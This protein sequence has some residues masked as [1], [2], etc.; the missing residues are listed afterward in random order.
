MSWD[1]LLYEDLVKTHDDFSELNVR[2]PFW[3]DP[4]PAA[5]H[6]PPDPSWKAS[7]APLELFLDKVTEDQDLPARELKRVASTVLRGY[8]LSG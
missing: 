7:E 1:F 5:P 2:R 3:L 6:K 8:R 4:V